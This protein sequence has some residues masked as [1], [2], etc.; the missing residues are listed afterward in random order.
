MWKL[1][2]AKP[3]NISWRQQFTVIKW[4]WSSS[5]AFTA[6]Y[7]PCGISSEATEWLG[8]WTVKNLNA[9]QFLSAHW[10]S[11]QSHS[12]ASQ[13]QSC[14]DR[15]ATFMDVGPHCLDSVDRSVIQ[16][17][18]KPTGRRSK[19]PTRFGLVQVSMTTWQYFCPRP[20]RLHD[21]KRLFNMLVRLIYNSLSVS[22][23]RLNFY[24]CYAIMSL[25]KQII[26]MGFFCDWALHSLTD[27]CININRADRLH[28]KLGGKK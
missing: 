9:A 4:N 15:R 6:M 13:K 2:S 12:E 24:W 27:Q 20:K 25:N 1:F 7:L 10:T 16:Q 17:K 23:A 5:K 22:V 26:K 14:S 11:L 8:E 3:H 21:V 19:I 28:N 18:P